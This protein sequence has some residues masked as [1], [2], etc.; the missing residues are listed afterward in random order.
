MGELAAFDGY[1]RKRGEVSCE[2]TYGSGHGEELR[3]HDLCAEVLED[4][5][6]EKG[7]A[8]VAEEGELDAKYGTSSYGERWTANSVANTQVLEP[9]GFHVGLDGSGDAGEIETGHDA[10]SFADF[11]WGGGRGAWVIGCELK[12]QYGE[13]TFD[14]GVFSSTM[15]KP[16]YQTNAAEILRIAKLP[17]RA[18]GLG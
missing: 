11:V 9:D 18:S 16:V 12:S 10:H 7:A 17:E 5:F 14:E 15:A 8:A 2:D 13:V 6:F 4:E 3:D 1:G